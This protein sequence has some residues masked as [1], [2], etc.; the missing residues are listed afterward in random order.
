[1]ANLTISWTAPGSCVGCTYEYRYKLSTDTTYITGSTYND[2]GGGNYNKTISSLT[3]GATYN[4]GVRTVCGSI[5]SAWS[6]AA[7]VTCDSEPALTATPTPTPTPT[8]AP[9][10]TPT[11]TPTPTPTGA[12]TATPTPTPTATPTPTPTPAIEL[13]GCGD[14][15]SDTY[16]GSGFYNFPDVQLDF[17]GVP[18]GSII[19]FT[20]TANDRPNN[21]SIRTALTVLESTGWFGNS[22][23]YDP[24]DYYYPTQTGPITL[25]I[26]YDN[27]KTYYIDTLTAPALAAPN[28]VN[29]YWE[30]S[31]QCLGVPTATPTPTPT[32]VYVFYRA[33]E[34]L[35]TNI[36]TTYCDNFGSGGQGYLINSPFYTTDAILTPGTTTIYSDYGLTTPVVGSWS[37]GNVTRMAYITESENQFA[38]NTP[39]TTN[40]NGDL[41]YDGGTYKFIRVDS[42]GGIIS[43]GT[44]SCSGGPGG[45]AEA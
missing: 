21:I 9:T 42:N 14:T 32:P 20:C 26:T 17:T 3:D 44:D 24:S 40:P 19:S 22:S 41:L 18:N 16:T 39:T 35:D 28:E 7:T 5:R 30:V 8:G 43:V 29:D 33:G 11:A 31:I 38:T 23:G 37:L 45:P 12:P 2:L 15:V 13:S 10:A 1:M 6:S 36:S 4:Y 34:V 25:S 27:T